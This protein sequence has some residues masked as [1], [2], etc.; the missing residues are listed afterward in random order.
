MT[1]ASGAKLATA[2][3]PGRRILFTEP[4]GRKAA[5]LLYL[6]K[7]DSEN[8]NLFVCNTGLCGQS[9]NT[10]SP[11]VSKRRKILPEVLVRGFDGC[12]GIPLEVD[13]ETGSIYSAEYKNEGGKMVIS[14]GFP[15]LGSRLFII[16]KRK[17]AESFPRR[18]VYCPVRKV[19]LK[20]DQYPVMLSEENVL[21]LDRPAYKISD[22]NWQPP[23]EVLRIDRQARES[24]ELAA[25][26][27]RMVQP[28]LRKI[29]AGARK[30]QIFLKYDIQVKTLPRGPLYLGMEKPETFAITLN[31]FPVSAD[32]QSGWWT[33]RSLKKLPINPAIINTGSNELLLVCDY[34]ENHPGF[35]SAFLLG[36][37]GVKL[38]AFANP[39]II[40]P[41]QSLRCGDW[42]RQGL[43]FYSGSVSYLMTF[44][45]TIKKDEVCFIFLPDFQAPAARVFVN[46]ADAGVI[47]W[48]PAE[49]DITPFLK[50]NANEITVELFGHRRNSHGPLHLAD[51]NPGWTGPGEFVSKGE[52]W[53]D[54]YVIKPCGLKTAPVI[55]IKKIL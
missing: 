41:A 11:P 42:T 8:F 43:P 29:N 38:A 44:K 23:E 4:S 39:V 31:G 24:L 46:G 19:S 49:L 1:A 33:D 6:L 9:P 26:G 40:A 36:D 32:M 5:E 7:E 30:I 28:W 14:T 21:V 27:G 10:E 20:R 50:K 25:R 53:Q 54:A 47:A 55:M 51:R 34:S 13:L 52:L 45:N 18:H 15:E 2:A 37:F 48:E 12:K 22:G 16:P 17:T 3:E 35:E